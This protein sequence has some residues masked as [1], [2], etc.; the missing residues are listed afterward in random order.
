MCKHSIMEKKRGLQVCASW[1]LLAPESWKARG[2]LTRSGHPMWLAVCLVAQSCPTL[3][4]PM[5]ACQVPLSMELPR[6]GYWSGLPF[7]SP[8][9]LHD[10]GSNSGFLHCSQILHHMSHQ[11]SLYGWLGIY[12][13]LSPSMGSH[14]VRHA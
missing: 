4:N 5:D 11:G 10:Q 8:G 2:G 9:D 13:Y 14:R 1:R 12:I 7:P 3:C 6:Q